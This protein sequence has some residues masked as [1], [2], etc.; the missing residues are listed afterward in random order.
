MPI[1]GKKTFIKTTNKILIILN[2]LVD[3]VYRIFKNIFIN[4]FKHT[5][6]H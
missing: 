1:N 2:S 6:K 4:H 5:E 3:K